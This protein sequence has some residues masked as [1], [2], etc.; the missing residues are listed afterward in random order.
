MKAYSALLFHIMKT[1]L[2]SDNENSLPEMKRVI[3]SYKD[4]IL[5]RETL[6]EALEEIFGN[7]DYTD[8]GTEPSE[9]PTEID[10]DLQELIE[11]ANELFNKAKEASQ[12]GNWA[13]Y[14]EYINQLEEVLKMMQ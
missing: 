13:E 11:R 2:E 3:V 10:G 12:N 6:K 8:D 5:M 7:I 14:G 9:E 4:Q 1:Y